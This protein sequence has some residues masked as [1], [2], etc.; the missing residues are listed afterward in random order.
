[1]LSIFTIAESYA[2]MLYS[3]DSPI[4]LLTKQPY[5][6]LNNLHILQTFPRNHAGTFLSHHSF[7][8][9]TFHLTPTHHTHLGILKHTAH[10]SKRQ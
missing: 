7:T 8:K 6:V 5:S 9:Y 10:L 3:Y 2:Y 4:S 1:M